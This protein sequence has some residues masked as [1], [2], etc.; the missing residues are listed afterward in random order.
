MFLGAVDGVFFKDAEWR[1]TRPFDSNGGNSRAYACVRHAG[2]IRYSILNINL[3]ESARV[4]FSILVQATRLITFLILTLTLSI[5]PAVGRDDICGG[6]SHWY[7]CYTNS[8]SVR[9]R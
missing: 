9:M 4:S 1:R 6:P 3:F 8:G 5:P 2:C 7:I